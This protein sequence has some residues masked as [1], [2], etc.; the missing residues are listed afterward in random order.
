MSMLPINHIENTVD[1]VTVEVSGAG[2]VVTAITLPQD[3]NA[4]DAVIGIR[5]EDTAIVSS[6]EEGLDLTIKVVER[7]GDRTLLYGTLVDG[8]ELI[9]EDTGRSKVKGGETVRVSISPHAAH[10]FDGN[11]LAHHSQREV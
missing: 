1:G 10:I 7:L 4:K 5:A 8:T 11:G 9:A 3:F 6:Q 2:K